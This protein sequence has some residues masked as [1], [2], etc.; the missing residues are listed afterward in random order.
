MEIVENNCVI[1]LS[2]T[3]KNSQNEVIGEVTKDSPLSIIQGKNNIFPTIEKELDGKKS[4]DHFSVSLQ[5]EQA[6]GSYNKN[7]TQVVSKEQFGKESANL[8]V[9]MKFHVEGDSGQQLV[10]TIIE[11]NDEDVT[12]DANHPLADQELIFDLQIISIRKA[13]KKE[14]K[15][16]YISA[17]K[18]SCSCC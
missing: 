4:G 16:G 7:L 15:D 2:Y 18:S 14:L 9:G 17:P 12:L 5:P 13:T 3:L 1:E 11:I 6:Y 8:E 10:A